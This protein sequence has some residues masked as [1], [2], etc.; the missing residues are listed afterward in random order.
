[1]D[2]AAKTEARNYLNAAG[3]FILGADILLN[4]ILLLTDLTL[5]I[6][7]VDTIAGIGL[8]I[9]AVLLIIL[10]KR[11]LS[12]IIFLMMGFT[13]IILSR[14]FPGIWSLL[15]AGSMFI[16]SLVTLTGKDKKKWMLFL[17]PL[18]CFVAYLSLAF[19]ETGII[20]YEVACV[21]LI[22][23]AI[24]YAVV[25]FYYAFVCASERISLPGR[26]LLTEDEETDFKATGS[27]LGYL[28]FGTIIG[29]WALFNLTGET[30]GLLVEELQTLEVISSLTLILIAILLYAVGKMRFTP[31]MFL[32]LGLTTMLGLFSAGAMFIGI[33]ILFLIIGLFSMLRKESRILPGIMLILHGV[34]YFI[35]SCVGSG[36]PTVVL[37][38]LNII[39]A[40]VSV[41]LAFAVYSQKKLPLF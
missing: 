39:V 14:M 38:I 6:A 13:T 4:V 27:I 24:C 11:D 29:T 22:I 7:A 26:K 1:M 2:E 28:I 30:I 36:I 9:V 32:L 16:V 15:L 19:Y 40:A 23:F 12:A 31:V 34:V 33:G 17:L 35:I 5:P 25:S 10:R 41:Y 21:W 20:G 18:I 3:F 37:G 8:L